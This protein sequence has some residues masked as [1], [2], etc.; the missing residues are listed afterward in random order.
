MLVVPSKRG[1]PPLKKEP[2]VTDL[3]VVSPLAAIISSAIMEP[4]VCPTLMPRLDRKLSIFW[5]IFKNAMAQRNQMNTFPAAVSFPTASTSD[6]VTAN[7][8]T[9]WEK[10][11][12]AIGI[13]SKNFFFIGQFPPYSDSGFAR[14]LPTMDVNRRRHHA[15]IRS[16]KI[17]PPNIRHQDLKI[18]DVD[19][20]APV[21][22]AMGAV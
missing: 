9:D 2:P 17:C 14:K 15:F 16:R 7:T 20:E 8:V 1:E 19:W 21:A 3:T 10:N 5:L 22:K 12:A 6:S 18:F 4:P 11:S 13:S